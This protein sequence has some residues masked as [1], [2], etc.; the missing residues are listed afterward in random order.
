MKYA[1]YQIDNNTVEVF[2]SILGKEEIVLNGKKVSEKYSF[3]GAD[4]PVNIGTDAYIIKPRLDFCNSGGVVIKVEKNG[5]RLPLEN[6]ISKNNKI[7]LVIY[8][9]L[10]IIVG[11]YVGYQIGYNLLNLIFH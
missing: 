4:H 11:A 8:Y 3:L 1:E 2:N 10:S 6:N 9:L 5:S 7:R